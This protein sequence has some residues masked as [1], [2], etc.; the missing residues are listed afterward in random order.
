MYKTGL[1]FSW[2]REMGIFSTCDLFGLEDHAV[3]KLGDGLQCATA[4]CRYLPIS[5]K[6]QLACMSLGWVYPAMFPPI[7][8]DSFIVPRG[9]AL[10]EYDLCWLKKKIM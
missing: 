3:A 5:D 9:E 2:S 4:Y 10:I 7:R 8:L 6:A 1:N